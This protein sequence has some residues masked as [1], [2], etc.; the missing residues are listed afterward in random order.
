MELAYIWIKDFKEGLINE[1]GFNFDNQYR[2]QLKI[3][4]KDHYEIYVRETPNYM[5]DL[6]VVKPEVDEPIAR[7]RNITAIVGQNGVGK[8]SVL[9]F[10][11]EAFRKKEDFFYRK[12]Q[13]E[14]EME[15]CI[16]IL[17]EYVD[18][19]KKHYISFIRVRD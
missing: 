5:E 14:D 19:E 18:G 1:Q 12:F 3:K 10:I 6:F 16:Y 11:K 9:D 7:I 2:Y 8:S 15:D 4:D 17:R 13:D